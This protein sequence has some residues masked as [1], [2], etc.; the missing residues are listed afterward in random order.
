[1]Y[2]V[3]REVWKRS[4][5]LKKSEDAKSTKLSSFFK[6]KL[7]IPGLFLFI[8]SLFKTNDNFFSAS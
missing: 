2:E 6:K 5:F 8:F 7:A 3:A 4:D 1:M